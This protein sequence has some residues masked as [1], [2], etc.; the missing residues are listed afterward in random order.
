MFTDQNADLPKLPCF[1]VALYLQLNAKPEHHCGQSDYRRV[2]HNTNN[3]ESGVRKL[4]RDAGLVCDDFETEDS[5]TIDQ[6][7]YQLFQEIIKPKKL[8][9]FDIHSRGELTFKGDT[10]G[11]HV[12]IMHDGESNYYP[13][14]S[15]R[16]WF[17]KKGYCFDCEKTVNPRNHKCA[18][19]KV[20][21]FCNESSCF[22]EKVNNQFCEIC[23]GIFRNNRCYTLHKV[24][25]I[26]ESSVNCKECG[27]WCCNSKDYDGHVKQCKKIKCPYCRKFEDDGHKC[28]IERSEV[29]QPTTQKR[30]RYV[31]YDF[32][33]TQ[34]DKDINGKN[35][36]KVNYAVAMVRCNNCLYN[37]P[38][39][40]CKDVKRF[41]GLNGENVIENFCLWAF[42]KN[43]INKGATFIAHNGGHYDMH[44]IMEYI[45]KEGILPSVIMQGGRI[46]EMCEKVTNTRWIDSYSFISMPLSKF[47]ETFNLP[48]VSK[49][50]FPHLFNIA[51]NYNYIGP[52]PDTKYYDPDSM[53]EPGRSKFME[54]HNDHRD[55]IFNFSV[56]MDKYCTD[57]VF[58]LTEGCMAFRKVF[59][60]DTGV[61]PFE[62]NNNS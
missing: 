5:R 35:V 60:Q 11:P 38:C 36:H 14:L 42:D 26:C 8:I 55:C 31:F 10:D 3:V 21:N 48:N 24:K 37:I 57:D 40:D 50:C 6:S 54:W 18:T 25:N 4:M 41:T 22:N 44:F 39:S 13:I 45:V 49:G 47:P 29:K 34:N 28:F 52:L 53:R 62:K 32:E 15:L 30:V 2:L 56:E 9:V 20:C 58:I 43:G 59:I 1:V 17:G 23:T 19:K 51:D 7:Q 61:D 46:L 12:T 16:S 33:S 27:K